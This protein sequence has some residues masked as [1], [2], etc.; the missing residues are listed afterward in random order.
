MVSIIARLNRIYKSL[1]IFIFTS[2]IFYRDYKILE[3]KGVLTV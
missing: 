3:L 2:I 1:V